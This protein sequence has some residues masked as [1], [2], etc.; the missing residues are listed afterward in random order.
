MQSYGQSIRSY[1]HMHGEIRS[2]RAN[3]DRSQK[4]EEL[5][6]PSG[7]F[8]MLVL[9]YLVAS[10]LLDSIRSTESLKTPQKIIDSL[11]DFIKT[12][13]QLQE[14]DL[15]ADWRYCEKLSKSWQ[16]VCSSIEEAAIPTGGL[17]EMIEA[18]NHYPEKGDHSLGYY[19]SLSTGENWIPFPFMEILRNL[20]EK[21]NEIDR[22]L[23]FG[24]IALRALC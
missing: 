9:S 13:H 4:E 20:H 5:N 11:K 6:L 21:K 19:L 1:H 10:T 15:S 23:K 17:N 3:K 18:I 7:A 16:D 22:L 8:P 12:L 14:E 2:E 24:E